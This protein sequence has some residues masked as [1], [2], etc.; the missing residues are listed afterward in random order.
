MLPMGPGANEF[1]RQ[2][3]RREFYASVRCSFPH[4]ARSEHQQRY[5]GA[6]R[7]SHARGRFE[8]WCEG[9]TGYP[10]VDAAMRQLQR[11]RW[12]HIGGG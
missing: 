12:V 3:C 6:L 11:E 5:R 8:A 9:R 2:L 1:H 4:N 10:M 7:W